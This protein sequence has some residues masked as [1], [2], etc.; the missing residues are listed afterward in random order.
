MV[1]AINHS[2]GLRLP[3]IV[4]SKPQK[5]GYNHVKRNQGQQRPLSTVAA[6]R[7]C[8]YETASTFLGLEDCCKRECTNFIPTSKLRE[9]RKHLLDPANNQKQRKDILATFVSQSQDGRSFFQ[10]LGIP[11]CGSFMRELAGGI[12]TGLCNSL[13]RTPKAPSGPTSEPLFVHQDGCNLKETFI[14]SFLD[15]VKEEDGDRMPN[16]NRTVLPQQTKREVFEAYRRSELGNGRS[17]ASEAFFVRVWYSRRPNLACRTYSKFTVCDICAAHREQMEAATTYIQKQEIRLHKTQHYEFI[18]DARALYYQIRDHSVAHP[19]DTMSLIIDGAAQDKFAIPFFIERTKS[20]SSGVPLMSG[21]VGVLNHGARKQPGGA[22][23]F[24]VP[25]NQESGSNVFVSCI[26]WTLHH[27]QR[28]LKQLGLPLPEKLHVQVDNCSRENKNR[29]SHGY[30]EVLVAHGVFKQATIDYLPKGHTHE[31]IDQ[32]FRVL[33]NRIKIAKRVNT[34]DKLR[35]LFTETYNPRPVV[36][37][38]KTT[39]NMKALLGPHLLPDSRTRGFTTYHH[40]LIERNEIGQ[41]GVR[42]KEWAHKL[43]EPYQT[44]RRDGSHGGFLQSTAEI[45]FEQIPSMPRVPL[46]KTEANSFLLLLKNVESRISNPFDLSALRSWAQELQEEGSDPCDWVFGED[47][48]EMTGR[49]S[50]NE[51]GDD[52]CSDADEE[53]TDLEHEPLTDL[54]YQDGDFV[55]VRPETLEDGKFWLGCVQDTQR[56]HGDTGP[57][58]LLRL[59]WYVPREGGQINVDVKRWIPFGDD[60]LAYGEAHVDSVLVRIPTLTK[61]MQLRVEDRKKISAMIGQIED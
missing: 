3:A 56:S 59:Q 40:F 39:T 60:E 31:D 38:L 15:T 16:E 48:P 13:L 54:A 10:V 12:S 33:G 51:S 21:I 5:R 49:F 36:Q 55:A 22:Y 4:I 27:E 42:V 35:S 46:K 43:D 6:K 17:P 53:Y 37:G 11:V 9:V 30:V 14:L 61:K 8:M 20:S 50:L 26:H 1:N 52:S 23:V 44:L 18:K 47:C 41:V 34:V 32:L 57:I 7:M 45:D 28:R 25:P 29:F 58:I 24:T 2:L 19:Q